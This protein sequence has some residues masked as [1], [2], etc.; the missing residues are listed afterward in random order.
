MGHTHCCCWRENSGSVKGST[1]IKISKPTGL[2]GYRTKFTTPK[3]YVG[4]SEGK[5]HIFL[6][7]SFTFLMSYLVIYS[8][9]GHRRFLPNPYP[10]IFIFAVP[11]FPALLSW[12]VWILPSR[13]TSVCLLHFYYNTFVYI[14]LRAVVHGN[15]QGVLDFQNII[16]F[17]ETRTNVGI[18][19]LMPM[20]TRQHYCSGLHETDKRSA[21]PCAGILYRIS[22]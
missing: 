2:E 14:V 10:I 8:L 7:V 18:I 11:T 3:I 5:T 19:S 9:G 16:R 22:I 4:D 17:H 15:H 13:F 6:P 20:K 12:G 1:D 21:D